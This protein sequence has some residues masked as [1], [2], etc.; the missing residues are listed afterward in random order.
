M[1]QPN[2]PFVSVLTPVYNGES[3]LAECIES[4]LAQTHRNFEYIIV[5][6]RSNDRTLEIAQR[7]ADQ[8]S[9]IKVYTNAEFVGVIDN[10]NRA[11]NFMSPD[12]KYCK[13]V[14]GDDYIFPECLTKM[15]ALAEANPSV[16]IVG[17]FQVS[18]TVVKW[19]GF[20]Y[21]IQVMSGR[22]VCKRFLSEPQV[23][24]DDQPMFGFGSPT[25]LLY[26]ADLVRSTQAFYPNPSP[27]SDTSACFNSLLNSD[28]GFVYE[29]L[30]YERTHEE[31]QTSASLKINRYLSASLDDTLHYGPLYLGK[32]A[33]AA[34]VREQLRAYHRFLATHY[35]VGSGN[36]EFWNYHKR[37]LA[38][39]GFPL[40]TREL[41]TAAIA[42][43]FEEAINPGQA[44]RKLKRRL[45]A[46]RKSKGK[47]GAQKTGKREE[48]ASGV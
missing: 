45:T 31:T 25:S 26:R 7:Y 1:T 30:S 41:Y 27:H 6:N 35:F 18:G 47:S 16:G 12:A 29:I 9:R 42:T 39:L 24:V 34:R 14:S 2:T 8:D 46:G 4:V 11:F 28:F 17:C 15:L 22:E 48:A 33:S 44:V 10:H 40:K 5:N 13:V 23:F 37:R 43:I 21:P 19:V 3:Y 36:E 32:V 38:E 20:R